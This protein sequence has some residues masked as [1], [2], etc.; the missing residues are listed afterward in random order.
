MKK[1][2]TTLAIKEMKIKTKLR[3]HFAPIKMAVENANK[4]QKSFLLQR[5]RSGGSQFKVSPRQIV[6]R[7]PI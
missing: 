7:E 2:S 5:Q 1:C 3:F 6:L 4:S